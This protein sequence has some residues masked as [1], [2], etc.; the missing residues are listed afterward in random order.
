MTGPATGTF[1]PTFEPLPTDDGEWLGRM[2]VLKTF[3]G[4][5]AGTARAEMLAF[6]SG[7]DGSAGYVAIDRFTGTLHGR[8]GSF[9]LQHSGLMDRG[10]PSLTVTVV[11]GSGTDGLTGLRGTMEIVN[12]GGAH[13]YTLT[14][15]L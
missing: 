4:D 5:L 3:E 13:S 11:P 7:E 15:R 6:Q 2:R 9:V 1:V 14:Y 10:E 8:R 12:D